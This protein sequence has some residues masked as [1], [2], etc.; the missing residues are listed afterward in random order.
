MPISFSEDG[1]CVSGIP[2]LRWQ[3]YNGSTPI[4]Y[5]PGFVTSWGIHAASW[6]ANPDSGLCTF[7]KLVDMYQRFKLTPFSTPELVYGGTEIGVEPLFVIPPFSTQQ[8][9]DTTEGWLYNYAPGATEL[10]VE[11]SEIKCS[12]TGGIFLNGV[13]TSTRM[14]SSGVA[15]VLALDLFG[16]LSGNT[17]EIS[18]KIKFTKMEKDTTQSP[19]GS[20]SQYFIHGTLFD[21]GSATQIVLHGSM[22]AGQPY[23][24]AE[25]LGEYFTQGTIS[26]RWRG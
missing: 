3:A 1:V 23:F 6:T 12:G 9:I 20:S 24:Y 21:T 26:W 16:G 19:V 13:G 8:T 4:P 15:S 17:A 11:L 22:T 14:L 7:G 18:G 10:E 2:V 5:T 25:T